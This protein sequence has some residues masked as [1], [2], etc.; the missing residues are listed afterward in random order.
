MNV[1]VGISEYVASNGRIFNEYWIEM[2][3]E[4]SSHGLIW[5]NILPF[6]WKDWGK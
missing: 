5:C 6:Y 1:V 3:L 4:G 2:D